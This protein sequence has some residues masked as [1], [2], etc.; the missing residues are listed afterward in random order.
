MDLTVEGSA[1]SELCQSVQA[2][3]QRLLDEKAK[4]KEKEGSEQ[5]VPN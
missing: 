4:E 1:G 2:D 5:D 3:Y